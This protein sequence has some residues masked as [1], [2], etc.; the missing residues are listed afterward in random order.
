V[1]KRFIVAY[2]FG[3]LGGLIGWFFASAL[4]AFG[5]ARA[6][7][8]LATA[9]ITAIVV[10][11]AVVTAHAEREERRTSARYADVTTVEG[12]ETT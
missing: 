1:I 5:V 9:V 4:C 8:A 10:V 12:G 6:C 11:S 2:A 7:A 3:A